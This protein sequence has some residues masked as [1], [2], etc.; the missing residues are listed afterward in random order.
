MKMVF[1]VFLFFFEKKV[2]LVSDDP[3]VTTDA[4][5]EEQ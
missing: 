4:S 1:R 5:R 2:R 3:F